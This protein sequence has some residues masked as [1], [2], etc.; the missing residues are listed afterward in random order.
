V[1]A[2]VVVSGVLAHYPERCVNIVS[3]VRGDHAFRLFDDDARQQCGLQLRGQ[4][5]ELVTLTVQSRG[6]GA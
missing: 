3:G 4:R 6:F 1:K 5:L 2:L